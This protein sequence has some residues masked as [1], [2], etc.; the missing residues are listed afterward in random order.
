VA[1][2]EPIWADGLTFVNPRG[3][4]LTKQQRLDNIK[5]GA[6]EVKSSELSDRRIRVYGDTAVATMQVALQAQYSG[7]DR[8]GKY[9]V[10]IVLRKANGTWQMVV[11]QMTPIAA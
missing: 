7:E 6:T 2:L 3:E 10:T 8:S 1:A 4:V 5:T 11:V 9:R